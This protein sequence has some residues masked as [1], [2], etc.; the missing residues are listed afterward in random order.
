[1]KNEI[2]L[3]PVYVASVS[4][5]KDSMLMLELILKNPTK[6]PLDYVV[7]FD[8]EIDYPFIKNVINKLEIELNKLN[9]PLK[10]I[11]PS[12]SWLEL[13]EKYDYPSHNIRWCNS[14][15]KMSCE[16]QFVDWLKSFGCRPVW[17]I[18]FCADEEK[19]FKYEIGSFNDFSIANYIYPLA[20]EGIIES[21]VLLWARKQD[22]FNN[23]YLFNNRCGCM[24][25]PMSA[26]KSWTYLYLYYREEY[27]FFISK[28]I[29]GKQLYNIER[30]K[31]IDYIVKNKWV[32]RHGYQ[33]TI[34]DFIE[35]EENK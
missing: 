16:K 27:D 1:M 8:L 15:Y 28:M 35:L 20:E 32:D 31:Y 14:K 17:Y 22:I 11:K 13:Y 24:G 21:D 4:G 25:C 18:G 19:R 9:I 34:F 6:Y 12:K 2:A 29:N 33:S 23:Y 10:R 26:L 3:K 5:G 30:G 7:Y